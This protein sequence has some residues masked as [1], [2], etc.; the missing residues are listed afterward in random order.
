MSE[1]CAGVKILLER[2]KSNPEDFEMLDFSVNFGQGVEG[3]FYQFGKLM[4]QTIAGRDTDKLTQ[5]WYDWHY[6]TEEERQALLT[7]FKDMKR[8][9]F[10]KSVMERVFDEQYVERQREAVRVSMQPHYNPTP[11]QQVFTTQATQTPFQTMTTT[12]T[13]NTGGGLMNAIGLGG[14]FGGNR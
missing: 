5:S 10:D 4:E 2:M 7:G 3:R 11:A 13:D 9:K 1:F 6:F 14:L 8:T 12:T